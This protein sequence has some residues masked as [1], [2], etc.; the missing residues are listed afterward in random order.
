MNFIKKILGLKTS[1]EQKLEDEKFLQKFF[2]AKISEN[3]DFYDSSYDIRNEFEEVELEEDL[4]NLTIID[5]INQLSETCY[6]NAKAAGWWDKE[7]NFGEM[8]ALIH[9]EISE[10]L[11]GERKGL[12]DDH[13]PHRDMVEVELA[14]TIIRICDMAGSRG[15]NLGE[16]IVEKLEYNKNRADH[17]KENRM[18]EGGKKF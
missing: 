3:L 14:D 6:N 11:E 8:I 15:Y 12:K 5:G 2:G 18:K 10:A 4:I 1:E 13:L 9:S 17:K 7:R 16:A